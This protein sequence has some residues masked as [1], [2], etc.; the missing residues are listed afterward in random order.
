MTDTNPWAYCPGGALWLQQQYD[1]LARDL[2]GV[3]RSVTP[4]V[5]VLGHHPFYDT[6]D[7]IKAIGK[8]SLGALMNRYKVDLYICGHV[9]HYLRTWPILSRAILSHRTR[10]SEMTWRAPMSAKRI[11]VR[12]C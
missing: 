9:H 11:T 12:A 3:N 10:L 4:W 2:A 1:W 5:V 7:T 8:F 6:E